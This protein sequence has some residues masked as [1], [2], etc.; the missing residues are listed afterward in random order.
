MILGIGVDIVSIERIEHLWREFGEKFF[1]KY[2]TALENEKGTKIKAQNDDSQ[3]RM[4]FYARRFAAKEAAAKAL[5]AP[6]GL[7]WHDCEVLTGEKGRPYLHVTG[8]VAAEAQ[9]QG[10]VHWHLS[11]SHD[12]GVAVAFVIA[13]SS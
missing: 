7:R 13:E 5:G 2:F 9:R 12:G 8:T 6:G 10:I 4:A 11:L 3:A 1:G